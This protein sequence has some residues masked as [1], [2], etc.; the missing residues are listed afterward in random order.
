MESMTQGG[1][2]S[3]QK[4][5]YRGDQQGPDGL[6]RVLLVIAAACSMRKAA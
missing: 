3:T 5:L 2:L 6:K 4:V 1:L